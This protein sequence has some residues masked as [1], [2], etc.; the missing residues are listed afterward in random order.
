M[1][2]AAAIAVA[3]LKVV[4]EEHALFAELARGLGIEEERAEALVT[5]MAGASK[6]T[7]PTK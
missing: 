1:V 7:F 3:D 6:A 2:V 4:P 5:E